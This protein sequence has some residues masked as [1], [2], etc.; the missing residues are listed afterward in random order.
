MKVLQLISAQS[1]QAQIARS[2]RV[3]SLTTEHVVKQLDVAFRTG[4]ISLNMNIG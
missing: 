1:A 2:S 3:A 4:V